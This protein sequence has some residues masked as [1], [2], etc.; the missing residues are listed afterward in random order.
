[1]KDNDIKTGSDLTSIFEAIASSN[2]SYGISNTWK[3]VVSKIGK[4][5]E[6]DD[7]SLTIGEKLA[8]NSHVVDL[9]NGIL[10]VETTHSGWIQYL[11][12]NQ[13]FILKGLQWAS[14]ELNIKNLAF[15]VSGSKANICDDYDTSM[16][17][18][19]A[20][21]DKKMEEQ[22]KLLNKLNEKQAEKESISKGGLPP[23]MIAR[24]ERLKAD[25]L[26]NS[27]K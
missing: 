23:E 9:K 24:F 12:M 8:L 11:R 22:E 17:K 6:D 4:K 2:N 18:L 25:M 10:L 3:K 1:M 14:P 20:E 21:S 15:R 13:K 16:K 26:T 27:E 5:D 7:E 19:A